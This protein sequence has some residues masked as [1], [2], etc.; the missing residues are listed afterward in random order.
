V[1]VVGYPRLFNER[2][3]CNVITRISP[4]EQRRMNRAADLLS[5]VIETVA[6]SRGFTYVD[7]R[8]AFLGHAVC[9]RPEWING[10]SWP[11]QESYH[12]NVQGQNGYLDELT[13]EL[14]L[15]VAKDHRRY[16]TDAA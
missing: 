5:D 4:E 16:G 8:D 14:S 3:P 7:V 15:A 9:D 2:Q 1:V 11:I 13:P 6:T 12:P 10:L